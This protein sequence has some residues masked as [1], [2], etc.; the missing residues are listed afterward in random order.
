MGHAFWFYPLSYPARGSSRRAEHP[1]LKPPLVSLRA[2][3]RALLCGVRRTGRS[4]AYALSA[5]CGLVAEPLPPPFKP[6]RLTAVARLHC[7]S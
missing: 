6:G 3:L 1:L 5:R 2:P 4:R 7:L